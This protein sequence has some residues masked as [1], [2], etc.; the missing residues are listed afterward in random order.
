[1]NITIA[2]RWAHTLVWSAL[3][4]HTPAQLTASRDECIKFEQEHKVEVLIVSL[5][6]CGPCNRMKEV[7]VALIKL[8]EQK[9][10]TKLAKQIEQIYDA[11][12]E[13]VRKYGEKE[14][15]FSYPT[16]LIIVDGKVK[17]KFVGFRSAQELW[18]TILD[19]IA[20]A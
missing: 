12:A 8:A 6:G 15:V 18:T 9:G 10:Y 7:V 1:M 14:K 4:L 19:V 5:K 17:K 11:D 16:I 2:A 13:I 20:H 3:L